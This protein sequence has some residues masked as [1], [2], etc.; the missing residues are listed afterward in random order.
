MDLR[1]LLI[2]LLAAPVSVVFL[3]VV[4]VIAAGM[5][6]TISPPTP[7]SRHWEAVDGGT[8]AQLPWWQMQRLIWKQTRARGAKAVGRRVVRV[9]AAGLIASFIGYCTSYLVMIPTYVA[10]ELNGLPVSKVAWEPAVVGA[11]LAVFS[12]AKRLR[13]VVGRAPAR[14]LLRGP[15]FRLADRAVSLRDRIAFNHRVYFYNHVRWAALVAV[16]AGPIMVV[17]AFFEETDAAS[18]PPTPP[19]DLTLPPEARTELLYLCSVLLACLV[20]R[21][22]ERTAAAVM[23]PVHA[24][25][26]IHRCLSEPKEPTDVGWANDPLGHHRQNLDHAARALARAG[27]GVDRASHGHP[28]ATVLLG[29]STYLRRFLAGKIALTGQYPDEVRRVLAEA[30]IVLAGP[31]DPTRIVALGELVNAFDDENQPRA[32]LRAR[33]PG[34]WALLLGRAGDTLERVSRIGVAVWAI[35]PSSW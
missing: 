16:F 2:T 14:R 13:Y 32:E 20:C 12:L 33:P 30:V 5:L 29:C 23:S 31:A 18:R 19:D 35:S 24:A 28:L 9:G 34:R 25:V 26:S 7:T 1:T 3:F 11:A 4:L 6:Q 10:R 17:N 21:I 15:K 22:L 27:N 8:I